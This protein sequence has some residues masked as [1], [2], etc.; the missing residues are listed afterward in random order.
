MHDRTMRPP[1]LNHAVFGNGRLLG[2]V[3]PTSAIEWLCL[4][5]FDSPSVF[6]RLLDHEQGGS[7]RIL[8]ASGE[9]DGTL[10]YLPN[11]NVVRSV[12]TADD[13]SWEVIDF[14]PR[15]PAGLGVVVPIEIMRVVRPLEGQ[16]QIVVDFD[17][18]PDYGRASP[19]LRE[20]TLGLEVDGGAVPL[21]LM[22]NVPIPYVLARR[23]FA[24]AHPLYFV[25]SYGPRESPP[26]YASV[27]HDLERTVAGWRAWARS[28]ALPAFA[29][30]I[31]L[32]SALCLKLHAYHDT[33]A[34]I[35]ATTT[36]IPE[37]M[38]TPRTWDYRFCW[39]RDSAFTVEALRRLSQVA[40]GE[41]LIRFLRDVAEAGP[42]QPVYSVDGGRELHEEFLPHLTGFGGNGHVRIGNAAYHQTQH[43]LMGEIILCLETQLSDPRIV[44]DEPSA[45]FPLIRRL[46][47]EA[48]VAADRPDTSIWEFRSM[49]RNYTFSRAMCW[50]AVRRGANLARRF[51]QRALA[52]EWSQ[53]ADRE[54]A[55]ILERGYSTSRGFFTQAL[56]G[57]FPD[58]SNLL[59]PTLGLLDGRDPRFVST[60]EAYQQNLVEHGLMLRYR[61]KDDFGET[62]SAF[63]ICSFWW[64]EAL[65]LMG[66]LEEAVQVFD[67]VA[68]YANPVG[69]F[70]EDI[71]PETGAL[72]G[73]F[74]QAYTHVGLIH[75]AMT[76][77]E[78]LEARDGHVRAWA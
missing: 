10:A 2:L 65:A 5:R 12:F 38:G 8:H 67:R 26:T 28:C 29:A 64:A 68:A 50:V 22:T 27:V 11:T 66:R 60:V 78:L 33:G 72:L 75:A 56:D 54:Q 51:G 7:F 61:N 15:I 34:I 13:G 6:G 25:L 21:H 4:P 71:D 70:S 77:G 36:S 62:T 69:L 35:A 9:L 63:T 37:A 31:V 55:L 39:L 42:L 45:Y 76:I 40:E 20:L 58:A 53:I 52:E 23:P 1:P 17:P 30:E 49:F 48:I 74:P 43:D 47:E 16:P 32:R 14:A 19:R 24:L 46:V 41:H 18:R 57:E 3:S 59:L 73:N 44:H